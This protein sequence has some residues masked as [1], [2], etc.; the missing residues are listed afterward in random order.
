MR[1]FALMDIEDLS[2]CLKS[3]SRILRP[4]GS[5]AFSITHPCF[6]GP[7]AS[8]VNKSWMVGDY[9]QDGFWLADNPKGVRGKVGSHHR[10]LSTYL[11]GLVEAGLTIEKLAEPRRSVPPMPDTVGLPGFLY[12]RC[13][14]MQW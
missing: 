10:T 13:R 8:Q 12:A 1:N 2:A 3:A 7:H 6:L 11:N 5:F 14:K 9:F 4:E